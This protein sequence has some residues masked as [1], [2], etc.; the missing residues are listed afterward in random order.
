M[1]ACVRERVFVCEIA[2]AGLLACSRHRSAC[3]KYARVGQKVTD[4][5]HNFS[6]K[7]STRILIISGNSVTE[8]LSMSKAGRKFATQ[9]I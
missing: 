9:Q 1:R 7:E 2:R 5:L 3:A 6:R 8:W 4:M